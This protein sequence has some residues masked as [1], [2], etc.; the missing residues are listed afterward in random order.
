V[1]PAG[2]AAARAAGPAAA[3]PRTR[4]A[5]NGRAMSLLVGARQVA[6]SLW[7]VEERM[8]SPCLNHIWIVQTLMTADGFRA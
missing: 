6:V 3:A 8:N 7:R 5:A 4:T 1:G 2:A